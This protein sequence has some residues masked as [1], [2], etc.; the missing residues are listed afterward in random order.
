MRGEFYTP[1]WDLTSQ[2]LKDSDLRG[3]TSSVCVPLTVAMWIRSRPR[4][5]VSL[6]HVRDLKCAFRGRMESQD[7]TWIEKK[8]DELF[9]SYSQTNKLK[10]QV[11]E[12]LNDEY[13]VQYRNITLL[14]LTTIS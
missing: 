7:V 13:E 3:S 5:L 8:F 14:L 4:L 10:L 9:L 12:T 1:E 11:G 6:G 2:P